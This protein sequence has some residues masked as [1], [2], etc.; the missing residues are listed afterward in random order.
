MEFPWKIYVTFYLQVWELKQDSYICVVMYQYMYVV[1]LCVHTHTRAFTLF[2]HRIIYVLGI[3]LSCTIQ[4][5]SKFKSSQVSEVFGSKPGFQHIKKWVLFK[6]E[7]PFKAQTFLTNNLCQSGNEIWALQMRQGHM[8]N[9]G[10]LCLYQDD[11]GRWHSNKQLGLLL[12]QISIS[13]WKS[14]YCTKE[15]N[16]FK[17][18]FLSFVMKGNNIKSI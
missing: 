17:L 14:R 12:V 3:D 2:A 11:T 4:S 7:N 6:F 16:H 5:K 9:T 1:P 18:A 15:H 13:A 10:T 8:K